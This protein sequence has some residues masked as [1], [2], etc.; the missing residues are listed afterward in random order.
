MGFS[1][2][3]NNELERI[4]PSD[5]L[6]AFQRNRPYN[7]QPQTDTGQR[8]KQEISGITMRDI[9]D[10]FVIGCFK[11][12]GLPTEEYPNSLYDLPWDDMDPIAVCQ[13][14]MCE[15]EKRMGIYPNV[16]KLKEKEGE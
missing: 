6:S 10:S 14:M 5:L 3:L 8:G 15:V 7:G 12:S 11:A 2:E 13:N 4:S 1:E 9:R 16:P